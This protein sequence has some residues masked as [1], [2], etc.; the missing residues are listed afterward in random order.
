MGYTNFIVHDSGEV[1]LCYDNVPIGKLPEETPKD[2]WQSQIAKNRRMVLN[3]C[4]KLC[5]ISIVSYELNLWYLM[6]EF[7]Q[8]A[9]KL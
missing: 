3:S 6:R 8:K 4:N 9:K 5:R 2:I 1:Y 7:I